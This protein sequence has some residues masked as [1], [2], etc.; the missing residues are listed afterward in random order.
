MRVVAKFKWDAKENHQ[1]E[2][3]SRSLVK[4]KKYFMVNSG[5]GLAYRILTEFL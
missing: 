3:L 5:K 1:V 4:R 2:T